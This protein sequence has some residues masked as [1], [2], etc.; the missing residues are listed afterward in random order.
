MLGKRE[1]GC[2]LAAGQDRRLLLVA[3]PGEARARFE[4]GADAVTCLGSVTSGYRL[5]DESRMGESPGA[6]RCGASAL[7]IET[8]VFHY[9][10]CGGAAAPPKAS[11]SPPP[12]LRGGPVSCLRRSR[13]CSRPIGTFET[14][15]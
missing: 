1:G 9:L 3:K 4:I 13:H 2:K 15:D 5:E 8:S 12:A 14:R 11:P 10:V 6:N 7:G